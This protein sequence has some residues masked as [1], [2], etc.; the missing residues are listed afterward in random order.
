MVVSGLEAVAIGLL[1]FRFMPGAAVYRWSRPAWA[2]LC[3]ASMFAFIHILVG[4][5]SGYLVDLTGPAWLA[6]MGVFA[7]FGIFTVLFWAWF[8]LRPSPEAEPAGD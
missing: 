3:G 5:S 4:P 2:L 8:R 7:A 1:P 6:A